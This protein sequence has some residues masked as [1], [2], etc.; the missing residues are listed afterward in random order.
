MMYYSLKKEPSVLNNILVRNRRIVQ[1]FYASTR[2]CII[3]QNKLLGYV[4]LS[5][6]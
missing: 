2:T 4:L 1:T 3:K 6:V 5:N